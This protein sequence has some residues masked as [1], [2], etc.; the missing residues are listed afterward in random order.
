L[1]HTKLER[2]HREN[3]SALPDRD[4]LANGN[5]AAALAAFQNAYLLCENESEKNIWH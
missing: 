3:V 1:R 2:R 5:F 4:V